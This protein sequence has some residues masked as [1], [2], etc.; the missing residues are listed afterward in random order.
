MQR[1]GL[2]VFA[3][4]LTL[5]VLAP[6][7]GQQSEAAA[8]TAIEAPVELLHSSEER[9]AMS[10]TGPGPWVEDCDAHEHTDGEMSSDVHLE[11]RVNVSI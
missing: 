11:F 5:A 10:L 2:I 1:E 3:L 6:Q 8:Q 9:P 7:G 4:L